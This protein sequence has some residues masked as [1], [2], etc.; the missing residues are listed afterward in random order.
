VISELT[1]SNKEALDK[2][3]KHL[4]EEISILRSSNEELLNNLQ[5][6]KSELERVEADLKK[7]HALKNSI[8]LELDNSI[9]MHEK[10]V[11]MRLKF[12]SKLNNLASI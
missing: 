6:T 4:T 7:E 12:E 8:V 3:N 1:R 5:R 9:Q 2:M 11:E 10:E